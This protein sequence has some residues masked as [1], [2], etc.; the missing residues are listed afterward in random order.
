[1]AEL[2]NEMSMINWLNIL[3]WIGKW[4]FIDKM[5]FKKVTELVNALNNGDTIHN[6]VYYGIK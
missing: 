1:M 2:V 5:I 6:L 3:C 4:N